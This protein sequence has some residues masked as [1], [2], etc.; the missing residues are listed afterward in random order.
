MIRR[1]IYAYTDNI[2]MI[3]SVHRVSRIVILYIK[4]NKI[5][6]TTVDMRRT[7]LIDHDSTSSDLMVL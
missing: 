3:Y 4:K 2:Y 1:D 5:G 7:F 6:I